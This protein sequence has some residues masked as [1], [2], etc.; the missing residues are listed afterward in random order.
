MYSS[1]H[2]KSIIIAYLL[3]TDSFLGKDEAAQGQF[4]L[5]QTTALWA[6]SGWH[7]DV[8]SKSFNGDKIQ[9]LQ[10]MKGPKPFCTKE[11]PSVQQWRKEGGGRKG[12]EAS[13][14]IRDCLTGPILNEL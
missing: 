1:F 10:K 2:T 3:S 9:V 5:S 6:P 8:M 14:T 13:V 11:W 4:L 7:H 12:T